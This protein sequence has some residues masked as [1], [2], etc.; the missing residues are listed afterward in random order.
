MDLML[1]SVLDS[2][3]GLY[4]RP[5]VARNKP[6]ALRSFTQIARDPNHPIG[7]HPEDYILF[8]IGV[9]SEQTGK[10][11]SESHE[12]LAKAIDLL[13]PSQPELMADA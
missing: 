9:F 12:A 13:Q 8:Y 7:Q 6:E 1:F 3:V 11:L 10:V 2:K 4:A 5:F